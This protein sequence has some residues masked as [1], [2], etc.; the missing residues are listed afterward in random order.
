[1]PLGPV[2]LLE[3]L[4]R[5]AGSDAARASEKG[6]VTSFGETLK[7]FLSDVNE[8]QLE[9]NEQMEKLAAGQAENLHDVMVAVEKASISFELL[10]EIRNKVLEAYQ[11][12]M[13]M[14]L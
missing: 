10:L 14:Q 6:E 3:R 5:I 7:K 1:M 13:R 11:E 9:A 12:I 4:P 8:L 2:Q